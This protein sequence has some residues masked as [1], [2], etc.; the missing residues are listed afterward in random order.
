MLYPLS[1]RRTVLFSLSQDLRVY[2]EPFR[3]NP[4]GILLWSFGFGDEAIVEQG[5]E[6]AAC[7][8]AEYVGSDGG[9]LSCHDRRSQSPR[10]VQGPAGYG[11]GDEDSAGE[12]EADG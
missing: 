8:G 2:H 10:R 9:E 6:H 3:P 4:D 1:Y 7:Y 5:G 12:G 11:A